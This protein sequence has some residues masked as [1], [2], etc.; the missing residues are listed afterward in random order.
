MI[1]LRAEDENHVADIEKYQRG[2]DAA[3]AAVDDLHLVE[4]EQVEGE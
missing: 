2:D 3:Q 1:E 4:I